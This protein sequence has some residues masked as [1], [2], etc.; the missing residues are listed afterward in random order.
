VQGWIIE[1]AQT[2]FAAGSAAGGVVYGREREDG[3]R[4]RVRVSGLGSERSTSGGGEDRE[5]EVECWPG[6]V[7][8]VRGD[9]SRASSTAGE[10]EGLRVLLAGQG[11]ARGSGGVKVRV[12][13][14][15]GIRAPTWDI[16][17]GEEKWMV[18]VD[19]AVL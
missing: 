13:D 4:V 6:G 10:D 8:F 15:V 3:F 14:V 19:W 17:V 16:D 1:A 12:G 7:L 9:A 5:E 11:G 18:G 2:G